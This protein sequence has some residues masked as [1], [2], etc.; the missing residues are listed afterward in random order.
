[1]IRYPFSH[2]GCCA[3]VVMATLLIAG[4]AHAVDVTI[5]IAADGY[6]RDLEPD[7]VFDVLF[8]GPHVNLLAYH[9]N[10]DVFRG[11][12]EFDI[13][14]IPAGS[15]ITNATLLAKYTGASGDAG[16]TLQFNSYPGN[17]T[18]ELSDF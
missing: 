6:G 8:P 15:T 5:P 12:M 18:V 1:M 14:S 4:L 9:Q 2:R 11:A 17:G 10:P 3:I 13:R 7:N 16:L